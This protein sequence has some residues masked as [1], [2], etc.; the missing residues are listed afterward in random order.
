MRTWFRDLKSCYQKDTKKEWPAKDPGPCLL[1][2]NAFS[3]T[4][5][6]GGLW[7]ME[8]QKEL[9]PLILLQGE[10]CTARLV[11]PHV[12]S[13]H[14]LTGH[15][16]QFLALHFSRISSCIQEPISKQT[17]AGTDKLARISEE[18]PEICFLK[19]CSCQLV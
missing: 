5:P 18:F 9:G 10:R 19:L 4:L 13:P 15:G 8:I 3:P 16:N 11:L 1:G 7:Q 12:G 2:S 17:D 14:N 6:P